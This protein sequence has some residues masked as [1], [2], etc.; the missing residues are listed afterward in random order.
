MKFKN[1]LIGF[2]FF[3]MLTVVV[4]AAD[5]DKNKLVLRTF[6]ANTQLATKAL[7]GNEL[8]L[9]EEMSEN[10]QKAY[11]LVIQTK[12]DTGFIVWGQIAARIP[13]VHKEYY[14]T[15]LSTKNARGEMWTTTIVDLGGLAKGRSGSVVESRWKKMEYK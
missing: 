3:I 9:N 15:L 4:S 1:Y 5:F 11:F 14:L 6:V 12:N 7:L 8:N 10:S 2:S 13:G